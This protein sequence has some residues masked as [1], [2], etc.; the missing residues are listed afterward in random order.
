[1]I[2]VKCCYKFECVEV[3]IISPAALLTKNWSPIRPS[4]WAV[5]QF[6]FQHFSIFTYESNFSTSISVNMKTLSPCL[7]SGKWKSGPAAGRTDTLGGNDAQIASRIWNPVMTQCQSLPKKQFF[8][9]RKR[10]KMFKC[11]HVATFPRGKRPRFT[12][13]LHPDIQRHD[14]EEREMME[15]DV[16]HIQTISRVQREK[17]VLIKWVEATWGQ[18][19][20]TSWRPQGDNR[21]SSRLCT[22]APPDLQPWSSCWHWN[23]IGRLHSHPEQPVDAFI[24][25]TTRRHLM[26]CCVVSTSEKNK[27]TSAPS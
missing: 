9:V 1:M 27:L 6:P 24:Q 25:S 15:W 5:K 16:Q 17:E 26:L 12:D 11:S 14:W 8:F 21:E 20:Q 19:G 23:L 18:R 13:S 7:K 10:R 22:A 3:E 2:W 4:H